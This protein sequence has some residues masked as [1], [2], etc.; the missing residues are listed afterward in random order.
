MGDA[1]TRVPHRNAYNASKVI[2]VPH[3]F[4]KVIEVGNF[5][6]AH[7]STANIGAETT[8]ADT[9]EIYFTTFYRTI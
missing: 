9:I 7:D 2:T 6:H 8:P 1:A 3:E 5:F 4:L